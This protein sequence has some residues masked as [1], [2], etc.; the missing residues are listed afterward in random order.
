MEQRTKTILITNYINSEI[1]RK[2]QGSVQQAYTNQQILMNQNFIMLMLMEQA[3]INTDALKEN[4]EKGIKCEEDGIYR[5][6]PS[7]GTW[8]NVQA[9]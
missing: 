7:G 3:G 5:W 8:L 1:C 4:I 9:P 2:N 6:A